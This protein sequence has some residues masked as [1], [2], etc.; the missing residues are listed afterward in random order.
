ME[1]RMFQILDAMNANDEK[2]NTQTVGV[3]PDLVS[4][5]TAKHGGHVTMG[6]PESV[7]F[8]LL[9]DKGKKPILLIIDISEYQRI[10]LEP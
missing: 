1:K 9:N 2:N 4:A 7:I 5:Q 8:D 10:Q 3:C 6:V